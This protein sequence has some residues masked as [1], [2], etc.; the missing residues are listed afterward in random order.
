VAGGSRCLFLVDSLDHLRWGGRLSAGAA[1]LGSALGVRPILDIVDGSVSLAGR[2]RTRAAAFER[3]ISMAATRA[4]AMERPHIAVHHLGAPDRAAHAAELLAEVVPDPV[5]I[6]P[7]SAVLGAHA[8]PR[9]LAIALADLGN[10]G[11]EG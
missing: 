6:T 9:V 11:H 4:A 2:V 7:V 8:G 10:H 1:A 5:V 3:L